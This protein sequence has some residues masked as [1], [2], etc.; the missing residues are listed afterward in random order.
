MLN[1]K[2]NSDKV[3]SNSN[4]EF[5]CKVKIKCEKLI[6]TNQMHACIHMWVKCL[7]REILNKHVHCLI[8]N[9]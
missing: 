3:V 8:E 5:V 7:I 1:Y 2:C 4:K 9:F 6:W